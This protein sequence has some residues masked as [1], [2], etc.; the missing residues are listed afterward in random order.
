[1]TKQV[2]QSGFN[3]FGTSMAPDQRNRQEA[4]CANVLLAAEAFKGQVLLHSPTLGATL[5]SIIFIFLNLGLA[6]RRYKQ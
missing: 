3:A 5:F 6:V 4:I 1:M 2:R